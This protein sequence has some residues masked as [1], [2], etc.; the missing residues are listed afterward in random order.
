MVATAPLAKYI[1][2]TVA[3][4]RPGGGNRKPQIKLMPTAAVGMPYMPP[5][6]APAPMQALA[7]PASGV[8]GQAGLNIPEPATV[9][10]DSGQ[11]Y[12]RVGDN[13]NGPEALSVTPPPGPVYNAPGSGP[14]SFS[15]G[16]VVM[17][18]RRPMIRPEVSMAAGG[19]ALV[20]LGP[21]QNEANNANAA[22]GA[23]QQVQAGAM[24]TADKE[25]AAQ[26]QTTQNTQD[27][28]YSQL[29]VAAP[30]GV[31][32]AQGAPAL[33]GNPMV[34]PIIANQEQMAQ[35]TASR[36]R[37]LAYAQ[38]RANNA[39]IALAQEPGNVARQ[40]AA[41]ARA[42][43]SD[44]NAAMT[45]KGMV[46]DLNGNWVSG[47]ANRLQMAESSPTWDATTGQWTTSTAA[48]QAA[49]AATQAAQASAAA[50]KTPQARI[51][52]EIENQK[53]ADQAQQQYDP[54]GYAATK[55]QQEYTRQQQAIAQ[56]NAP[57][58]NAYNAEQRNAKISG[59]VVYTDPYT[60]QRS[61]ISKNEADVR[62]ATY[63]TQLKQQ[64]A[65]LVGKNDF[66]NMTAGDLIGILKSDNPPLKPPPGPTGFMS[67]E[68][69]GTTQKTAQDQYDQQV[70]QRAREISIVRESLATKG[71]S[72]EEVAILLRQAL[73]GSAS[74][75]TDPTSEFNYGNT[76][77]SQ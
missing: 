42:A 4:T 52:A 22:L 7:G 35:D 29:G 14:P 24:N 57:E 47:S 72:P 2:R 30:V 49:D 21:Y 65:S 23:E 11:P 25:A 38:S 41:D 75:N 1:A 59:Q 6:Q 66:S 5:I 77:A 62:D 73:A 45:D 19:S 50:A 8:G 9:V 44:E 31:S 71:Y 17:V 68:Q 32:V 36:A 18:G 37:A 67:D 61:T 63:Q 69:Y 76:P 55:A 34:R 43:R 28:Q 74:S 26:A 10:G 60:G 46:R 56:A 33:E 51:A 39:Q 16:G 20:G 54:Q 70:Q 3:V 53:I 12:I 13:P 58:D 48:H 15:T 64:M 27:Q 40:Q